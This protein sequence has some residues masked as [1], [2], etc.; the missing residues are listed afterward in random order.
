MR[1]KPQPPVAL[2]L[3]VQCG[4]PGVERGRNGKKRANPANK[5]LAVAVKHLL[6]QAGAPV[7]VRLSRCHENCANPCSWQLNCLGGE[8]LQF[9]KAGQ[10][11][12]PT[13]ADICAVTLAYAALPPG[14]RLNKKDFPAL[15]G[16]LV[17]RIA[18]W[19]KAPTPK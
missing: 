3:C 16:T 4:T 14:G 8:A 19:P 6:D 10:P 7:R 5:K 9:G 13:A 2:T 18:P 15:K 17:A 12:G 1:R 11:G